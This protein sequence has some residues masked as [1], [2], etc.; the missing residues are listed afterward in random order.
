VSDKTFLQWPFFED[1]HRAL[2]N[3]LDAWTKQEIKPFE[4]DEDDINALSKKFVGM[5][6]D[7]GFLKYTVPAAYGGKHESLDVRSLCICRETLARTTG[8]ADFAF[9]MQG[10]GSGAISLFG[11]D[12]VKAHY[13]PKV[14]EGKW[15]PAFGLTE[16]GAGSDAGAMTSTAVEDGD[17]YILNGTKTFISNA[18]IADFYCMFVRTSDE[19]ARGITAFVLDADTPGFEVTE[20]LDVIAPHPLGTV[21]MTDCRVPKSKMLGNVG[22]GFKVA[23]SNLDIF[24]STVG[25][26]SL[27]FARRALDE[28]LDRT[29]ERVVFGQPL[30]GFQFTQGKLADMATEIDT[31][32]LLVYRAAWTRDCVADRVTREAAMAKMYATEAAQVVIDH[33]VQLFGGL[34]V[35]VGTPVER[36]YREIRAMRIY[37]GTTDVQKIVIATQLLKE[38]RKG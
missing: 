6:G 1:H 23:M 5:M 11:S 35:L 30:S 21:T 25:A 34:G 7:A 14:R 4:D 18:G 9:A 29:Q 26:A 17:D 38:P 33:A 12:T 24:R 15:I 2:A 19:G 16:P 10:L 27:G 31:S 28:A 36:L 13:L 37:E 8:L 3:E 32:A 20:S 22:E